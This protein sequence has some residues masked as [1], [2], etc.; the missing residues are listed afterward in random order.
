MIYF[1]F[2]ELASAASDLPVVAI[3]AGV[4]LATDWDTL[5]CISLP[6]ERTAWMLKSL[7]FIGRANH[8]VGALWFYELT[9]V[10]MCMRRLR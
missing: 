1:D 8:Y 3:Q 10:G 6:P 7:G 2:F 5:H 9:R 4:T